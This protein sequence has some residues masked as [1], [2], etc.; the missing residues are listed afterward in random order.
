MAKVYEEWALL[1][2]SERSGSWFA[3]CTIEAFVDEICGRFDANGQDLRRRAGLGHGS[4]G[5]QPEPGRAEHYLCGLYA[6]YSHAWSPYHRGELIRGSMVIRP[7]RGL[8]LPV[9]YRQALPTGPIEVRGTL[10]AVGRTLHAELRDA[11][12]STLASLT[13]FQPGWPASVLCGIL[14]GATTMG[15]DPDP[16]ASRIIF[17]RVPADAGAVLERGNRYMRPGVATLAVDLAEL[18]V[19]SAEPTVAA[20]E[21][22]RLLSAPNGQSIIRLEQAEQMRLVSYFD[23]AIG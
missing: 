11:S 21:L 19:A 5:H 3:A 13:T 18:G 1:L 10:A 15:P 7:G 23:R 20:G 2:R 8:R 14:S 17:V 12:E 6:A 9:A 4:D 22:D 16:S